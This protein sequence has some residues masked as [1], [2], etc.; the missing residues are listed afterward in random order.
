MCWVGRGPAK[1]AEKDIVVYKLGYLFETSKMF[2]SL[3]QNYDYFPNAINRALTLVP[4]VGGA[5]VPKLLPTNIGMIQSGY[6]SYRN[7]S[8]PFM[9]LGRFSRII[10]LGKLRNRISVYNNYYVATF[11][12]PKGSTYYENPN[13]EVV[14]S[15]IRYTG[16][17]VK[18]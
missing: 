14:S 2:R 1:I 10:L 5:V 7:I 4:L 17:Y 6:H 16:K 12:I 3:Y 13:G 11:I 15:N 18:L 8:L 9:E